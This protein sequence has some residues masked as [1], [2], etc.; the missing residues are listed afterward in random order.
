MG[1]GSWPTGHD[2]TSQRYSEDIDIVSHISMIYVCFA[3]EKK[4]EE[5]LEGGIR[6]QSADDPDGHEC[7]NGTSRGVHGNDFGEFI[8][9]DVRAV[10][11][12]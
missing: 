10:C 5:K 2:R 3:W 6:E 9:S 7:P 11:V 8:W 1:G 4:G 12:G